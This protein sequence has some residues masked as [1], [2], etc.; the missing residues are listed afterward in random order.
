MIKI[1]NI[2][3]SSFTLKQMY[4]IL[5]THVSIHFTN[6]KLSTISNIVFAL[7]HS[8]YVTRIGKIFWKTKA[9]ENHVSHYHYNDTV[10][11]MLNLGV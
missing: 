4:K 11:L 9:L 5:M 10:Y 3:I 7:V 1:Q 8:V 2:Q 6:G